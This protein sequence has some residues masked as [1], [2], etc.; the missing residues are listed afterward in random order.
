MPRRKVAL[1]RIE[2]RSAM[3]VTFSKRRKGLFKKA[4][5]LSIMCG[6]QVLVI[7]FSAASK[8]THYANPSVNEILERWRTHLG[9]NQAPENPYVD[10]TTKEEIKR[11][12]KE[13]DE[14]DLIIS[15]R[16]LTIRQLKGENLDNLSIE[17]LIALSELTQI[18][19][20]RQKEKERELYEK[21][22]DELQHP[23]HHLS[24]SNCE[25]AL[26]KEREHYEMKIV[27]LQHT[28]NLIEEI[29][30]QKHE[31]RVENVVYD[32][33]SMLSKLIVTPN[34]NCE[35]ALHDLCL[36]L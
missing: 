36:K 19:F 17:Q 32:Q 3:Q 28:K 23:S 25:D 12:R 1:E 16:D 5:E 2:N 26:H 24:N 34:S 31:T 35:N 21:T 18:G 4:E 13:V 6:A 33:E 9:T 27:E 22:I 30:R 29:G 15:E 11:L 14:R 8:L 10:L 7:V 20:N